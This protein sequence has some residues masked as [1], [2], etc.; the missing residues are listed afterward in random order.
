MVFLVLPRALL[1][2]VTTIWLSFGDFLQP[3]TVCDTESRMYTP[4]P[5]INPTVRLCGL[6]PFP[7]AAAKLLRLSQDDADLR[8]MQP[9]FA[10]DPSLA[11]DVLRLANSPLFPIRNEVRTVEHAVVLLGLERVRALATAIAMRG[12]SVGAGDVLYKRCWEHSVACAV[13]AEEIAD[14]YA[15]SKAEAYTAGLLHDIGRIGLLKAYP[16]EYYSVLK[17]EYVKPSE[18]LTLERTLLTM[19]HCQAGSFLT[20]IWTFP[21]ALQMIA[22]SHHGAGGSNASN[23]VNLIHPAC[24]LTDALG[25]AEVKHRSRMDIERVSQQLLGEAAGR[26]F[27]RRAAVLEKRAKENIHQFS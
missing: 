21:T 10:A 11:A 26:Q 1:S 18:N 19:D 27:T 14:F 7:A 5:Q 17:M 4:R 3:A 12:Y 13:V 2:S 15:V 6:A 22:A 25:F 16:T 8:T 20:N 23:L 9:I 24:V